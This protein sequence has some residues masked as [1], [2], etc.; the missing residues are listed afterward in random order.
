MHSRSGRLDVSPILGIDLIHLGK[1]I[2]VGQEDVDLNDFVQTGPGS[3]ENDSEILNALML[4][5][6]KWLVVA[7]QEQE[8][9]TV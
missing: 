4:R 6:S 8:L 5:H 2:D 7:T 1:I 9:R 3:F